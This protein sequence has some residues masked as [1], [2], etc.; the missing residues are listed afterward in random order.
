MNFPK[1]RSVGAL[2]FSYDSDG[3]VRDYRD[4]FIT[5]V[6]AATINAY[7]EGT[8]RDQLLD[9]ATEW[10]REQLD[11]TG[12][13]KG[14]WQ[15]DDADQLEQVLRKKLGY[16]LGRHEGKIRAGKQ[17]RGTRKPV[18][19]I[20]PDR[21][22]PN[23]PN[24]LPL[25]W[26]ADI[27]ADTLGGFFTDI[28]IFNSVGINNMTA[29]ELLA[30]T[31]PSGP[32]LPPRLLLAA[33]AGLG[34]THGVL[35]R[36]ADRFKQAR[37]IDGDDYARMNVV[38]AC[39][40]VELAM[41]NA[42]TYRSFGGRCTVSL[43]RDYGFDKDP[44]NTPCK[45]PKIVRAVQKAGAKAQSLC[46]YHDPTTGITQFCDHYH[47]C[48]YQGQFDPSAD[49]HFVAHSHLTHVMS[50]ARYGRIELLVIDESFLRH[51]MTANMLIPPYEIAHDP[52]GQMIVSSMAEGINPIQTFRDAGITIEMLKDRARSLEAAR[53]A[54]RPAVFPNMNEKR[55]LKSFDP[56]T[57]WKPDP[58]V[59]VL[60]R[61]ADEYAAD[62]PSPD[63]IRCL[64]YSPEHRMADKA[65]GEAKV[66]MLFLR[67]KSSFKMLRKNMPVL[68]LDATGHSTALAEL[69]IPNIQFR[70]IEVERKAT[71][72]QATGIIGSM[73]TLAK[74]DSQYNADAMHIAARFAEAHPRMLIGTTKGGV[75]AGI[76][77]PN[78]ISAVAHYGGVQGLNKYEGFD[79][80]LIAGRMMPGIHDLENTARALLYD[81]PRPLKLTGAY[82]TRQSGYFMACSIE[83]WEAYRQ[84]RAGRMPEAYPAVEQLRTEA[85]LPATDWQ[86]WKPETW[87]VSVRCHDDPFIEAI[88]FQITEAEIIQ[89]I[90][91]PR[92]A[93]RAKD[94]LII[95]LT[96]IPIDGVP[97]DLLMPYNELVGRPSTGDRLRAAYEA[98][99]GVLPPPNMLLRAVEGLWPSEAAIKFELNEVGDVA[100]W[101]HT[102]R[103]HFQIRGKRGR[104]SVIYALEREWAAKFLAEHCPEAVLVEPDDHPKAELI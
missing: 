103:W 91:R 74:E 28:P 1:L 34:K 7:P 8:E 24:Q 104:P 59:R 19:G 97:V 46:R 69:H 87:G 80:V 88:R 25:E 4:N 51:Q 12:T 3:I 92:W 18:P 56:A 36:L 49:V 65:G 15:L 67:Y 89:M 17:G 21:W 79:A 96:E 82:S 84:I 32:W 58:L 76:S 48:A 99:G 29:Q 57:G 47:D 20:L 35:W 53:E 37:E 78:D 101:L 100:E 26:A 77:P 10:V 55:A 27:L 45:I 42:A 61:V 23:P 85:G 86:H 70:R 40:T 66:P 73:T 81:D 75:A 43:G 5:A 31:A 94:G 52:Y 64:S 54:I 39:P 41:Q 44:K 11:L 30:C 50:E 71:V 9:H 68:V 33:S 13:H 62:R 6:V 38:Y 22:W 14:K 98:L 95:L 16:A 63:A 60:R 2:K 90:D 93:R 72:L 83:D 102:R